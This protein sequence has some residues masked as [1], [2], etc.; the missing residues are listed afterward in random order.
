MGIPVG[1]FL[2]FLCFK[3][4]FTIFTEINI[5]IYERKN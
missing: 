4:K 1:G 5:T 3:I 2:S